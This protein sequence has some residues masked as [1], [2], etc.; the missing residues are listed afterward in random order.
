MERSKAA[1][2]GVRIDQMYRDQADNI[3]AKQNVLEWKKVAEHGFVAIT[4]IMS[5]EG[6]CAHPILINR[7][8]N[9]IRA[10]GIDMSLREETEHITMWSDGF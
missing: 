8:Y 10:N 2:A 5:E 6:L 9:W 7:T 1:E 3:L 4:H